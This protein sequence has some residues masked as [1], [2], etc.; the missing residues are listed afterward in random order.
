MRTPKNKYL[1][2]RGVILD[3]YVNWNDR[4]ALI[5]A[6]LATVKEDYDKRDE[7]ARTIQHASRKEL[8][9]YFTALGFTFE[10]K[11]HDTLHDTVV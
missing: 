9:H 11:P 3:S 2:H 4:D 6:A 1:A 5:L 10:K 7:F 8:R